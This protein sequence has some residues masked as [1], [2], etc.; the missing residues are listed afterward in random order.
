MKFFIYAAK[1]MAS[2]VT[3]FSHRWIDWMRGT[4]FDVYRPYAIRGFL[5]IFVPIHQWALYPTHSGLETANNAIT[6]F[7]VTYL[8]PLQWRLNERDGVLDHQP[9][10]WLLNRFFNAQIKENIKALCH[11][12]LCGELT[13]HRWIPA[14]RAGNG[15]NVSIWW[16][17]HAQPRWQ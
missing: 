17:H 10:D 13:G 11:W 12:T 16:R 2:I 8:P 15:E 9:H 14:Q 6:I 1:L 4:V 3:R 7:K 5:C